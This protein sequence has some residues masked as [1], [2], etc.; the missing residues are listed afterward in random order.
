MTLSAADI[1]MDFSIADLIMALIILVVP[2]YGPKCSGLVM[3]LI[4]MDLIRTLITL[5]FVLQ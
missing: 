5:D 2:Y 3:T 1:I 4:T